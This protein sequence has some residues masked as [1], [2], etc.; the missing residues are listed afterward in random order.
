MSGLFVAP[1]VERDRQPGHLIPVELDLFDLRKLAELIRKIKQGV[2]AELDNA[3]LL[4]IS[5]C[6]WYL[7]DAVVRDAKDL[8]QAFR[9]RIHNVPNNQG[10]IPFEETGRTQDAG[11][12]MLQRIP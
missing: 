2:G 9:R 3:E 6:V 11:R 5:E 8:W 1:D 10:D 4:E 12:S 7:E